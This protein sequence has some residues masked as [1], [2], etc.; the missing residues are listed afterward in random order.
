MPADLKDTLLSVWRQVMVEDA[1]TVTFAGQTFPVRAT[2]RSHLREVDFQ[3]EEL[4]LRALEQN[5]K[6]TSRWAKLARDGRKVMQFLSQGR[7]LA[8]VVDGKVQLYGNAALDHPNRQ[9]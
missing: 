7:Y 3:F 2:S 9:K 6:T 4:E 5:P 1:R 8:V